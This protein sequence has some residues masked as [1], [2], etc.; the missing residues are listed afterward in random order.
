MSSHQTKSGVLWIT[1]YSAAGK[2]TVGRKVEMRLRQ[3]GLRTIFLDGD[4]LRSIFGN[5][6]G[7]S[8]EDRVDLA[9]IY[10]RLCSHLSAQEIVVIISAVAMYNETRE[11]LRE[12]I[13]NAV[14]AYLSV[15]DDIRRKRDSKTKRIYTNSSKVEEMYDPPVNADITVEN[16]SEITADYAADEIVAYF[17]KEG[18]ARRSDKGRHKHWNQYYSSDHAPDVASSFAELVRNKITSQSNILEVGCGHGR[19]A[20]YFQRAGHIVT[21]LDAS[22]AA[23]ERCQDK[24]IMHEVDFVCGTLDGIKDHLLAKYDIVYSRFCLHAMTTGEEC[25]FLAASY[26][27]LKDSGRLFLECRS[28]ND[29][30]ARKGEILSPTERIFGHYRRFIVLDELREKISQQGFAIVNAEE[31][32]GLAVLGDDDPVVI[33]IEAVKP[34][35]GLEML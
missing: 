21:A 14:E 33:R 25:E 23:I 27:L 30:L 20:V 19:D 11:W 18:V 1:G 29:P 9:K 28:I 2:T 17:L 3:K 26:R 4:D 32:S 15:P 8:R 35:S 22:I 12:N 24:Y 16:Y 34:P 5:R 13:A 6:W 7:Y 31:S 10:F